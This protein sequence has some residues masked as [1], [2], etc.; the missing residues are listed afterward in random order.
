VLAQVAV[1]VAEL[2]VTELLVL[3][4]LAVL[5]DLVVA[6]AVVR[7]VVPQQPRAQAA[8]GFFTFSTRSK[9]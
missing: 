8:Q 2:Q 3:V 7:V 1:V 9:L 6:A 4:Q 5:V